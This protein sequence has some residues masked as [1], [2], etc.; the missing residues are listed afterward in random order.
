MAFSSQHGDIRHDKLQ[1]IYE[2]HAFHPPQVLVYNTR[3]HGV[4]MNDLNICPHWILK[5]KYHGLSSP[6][7]NQCPKKKRDT[8]IKFCSV[9]LNFILTLSFLPYYVRKKCITRCSL[10]VATS[11]TTSGT[12]KKQKKFPVFRDNLH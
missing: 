11:I 8:I 4:G 3:Y 6:V 1:S 9:E 2:A 10:G 7:G 12:K 5:S